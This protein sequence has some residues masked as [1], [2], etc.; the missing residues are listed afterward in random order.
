[1]II[2]SIYIKITFSSIVYKKTEGSRKRER[3]RVRARE[4]ERERASQ[5]V[6]TITLRYYDSDNHFNYTD[7]TLGTSSKR[8]LLFRHSRFSSNG[9]GGGRE[10]GGL[11]DVSPS[12]TL[13]HAPVPF[14]LP[15]ALNSVC[16]RPAKQF[17]R[18]SFAKSKNSRKSRAKRSRSRHAESV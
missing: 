3:V 1:M 2:S 11:S 6:L 13:L 12:S 5:C 9:L 10:G 17:P 14:H 8:T 16:A 18:G 7:S 4:R 15:R